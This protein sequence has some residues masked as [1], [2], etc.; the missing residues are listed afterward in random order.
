MSAASGVGSTRNAA[1]AKPGISW[2]NSA[3]KGNLTSVHEYPSN[4]KRGISWKN[5]AGV[6]ALTN[7]R[8]IPFNTMPTRTGSQVTRTVGNK[9]YSNNIMRAA[10]KNMTFRNKSRLRNEYFQEAASDLHKFVQSNKPNI[11]NI[12][13]G[14]PQVYMSVLEADEI[15]KANKREQKALSNEVKNAFKTAR[16]RASGS[17]WGFG[18]FGGRSRRYTRRR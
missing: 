8:E 4:T 1:K 6:G 3:G 7:V 18:W 12:T 11:L 5:T 2:K 9:T 10:A 16:N 14:K 13:S 17:G 15:H